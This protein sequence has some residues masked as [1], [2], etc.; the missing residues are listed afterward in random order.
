MNHLYIN[1]LGDV[2]CHHPYMCTLLP[3]PTLSLRLCID[4]RVFVW[5][6]VWGMIVD[7]KRNNQLV[8]SDWVKGQGQGYQKVK[9]VYLG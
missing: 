8:G 7:D 2:A 4:Q 5:C 9:N 1:K 6:Y 3:L